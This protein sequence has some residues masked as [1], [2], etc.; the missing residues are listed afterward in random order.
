MKREKL[1]GFFAVAVAFLFA[2]CSGSVETGPVPTITPRP[3]VTLAPTP[4]PAV[5]EQQPGESGQPGETTE[6]QTVYDTKKFKEYYEKEN[7]LPELDE[8][9]KDLFTVGIDALQ[10]DITDAKRQAIIK[11][12]FN[13]ISV[14]ED[15]SPNVLMDYEASAASGDLTR[16]SLDFSGADV[17][18]K[19]AQE[20]NIPVRGPKLITNETPAWAFTQNFSEAQVV[21]TTAED[22][23]ETT[24]IEYASADVMW[25]RMENYI[26]DVINYC[27]TNYPGLVISWDVLDDVISANQGQAQNYRT[28]SQWYQTLGDTYMVKACEFARKYATADQKLFFSQDGLD[29]NTV[30]KSSLD[31]I[32]ILKDAKVIDGVAIQAHYNPNGPNV[33]ALE[34]MFKAIGETGLEVHLTEFHVDS[35]EGS[36]GDNDLTPE[37][38]LARCAKRYKNLMT[39]ICNSETKKGYDIVNITVEGLT[40]DTSSLNQPKDYVDIVTGEK[41]H[42][43]QKISYPYFFDADLN[44]KD[45]FFAMMGDATI[46]GY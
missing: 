15:L 28:D 22:G 1:I 25:A 18:L 31:L 20:N 9:Y 42:G 16:I 44:V 4:T 5:V 24:T 11:N 46:K 39:T 35:N 6:T 43:V 38:L 34:G 41:M 8:A 23:T 32:A 12:Q 30:Q 21:T 27:N 40:D 17:I 45:N 37:E 29:E 26:K 36:V 7:K 13:T 19:F 33:F 14:K 10:I 3:A 2:G